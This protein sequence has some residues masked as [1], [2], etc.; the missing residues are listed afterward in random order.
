MLSK[1][2]IKAGFFC[3]LIFHSIDHGVI[4]RRNVS[5]NQR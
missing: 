4:S 3:R 2:L 1:Y 5:R